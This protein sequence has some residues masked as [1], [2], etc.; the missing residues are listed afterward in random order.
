MVNIRDIGWREWSSNGAGVNK[1]LSNIWKAI[2]E[3]MGANQGKMAGLKYT[4]S[5]ADTSGKGATRIPNFELVQW[6]DIPKA[7]QPPAAPP[8]A[9]APAAPAQAEDDEPLF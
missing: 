2:H 9:E 1:G 4:G 5:T 6:N 3:G 8:V 7:E